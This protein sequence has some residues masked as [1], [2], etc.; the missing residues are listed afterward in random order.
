MGKITKK[1]INTLMDVYKRN[2]TDTVLKLTDPQD[3]S[4]VIMEIA[5]KTSLTIPEKGIFVDRVVMPCFDEDGD[6]MPQYLDP[7]FMIT[8]LQM[9]TNVPPI[10]DA[11]PVLDDTGNETGEKSTLIN[12][13]KTYELCKAINLVKNVV[14][15][16]YQALIGELRQMVADKLAYVKD[17]NARK[18]SNPLAMLKLLLAAVN[19]VEENKKFLETLTQ[20]TDAMDNSNVGNNNVISISDGK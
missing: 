16:K 3:N 15:T 12:I 17:I 5:L 6:F 1:S 2:S 9:T 14:D 8:M 18:A 10:E 4:S 11:I 19:D 20:I 13:E 7:L